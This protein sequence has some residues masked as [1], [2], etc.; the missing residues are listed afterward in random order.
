MTIVFS[1]EHSY[2]AG[3]TMREMQLTSTPNEQELEL[4]ERRRSDREMQR[5]REVSLESN[6]TDTN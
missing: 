1:E 6:E 3:A 5:Y 2:C 4:N